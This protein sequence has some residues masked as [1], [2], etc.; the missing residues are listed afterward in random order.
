MEFLMGLLFLLFF[1]FLSPFTVF[2]LFLSPPV[3]FIFL[4]QNIYNF[5]QLSGMFL[6]LC[7]LF[8]VVLSCVLL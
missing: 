6:H 7:F 1:L 5:L 4:L 8:I 2:V 3:G